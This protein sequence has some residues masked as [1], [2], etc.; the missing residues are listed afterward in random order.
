MG[1]SSFGEGGED[2]ISYESG[3]HCVYKVLQCLSISWSASNLQSC[4]CISVAVLILA[5]LGHLLLE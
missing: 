2:T 3:A 5:F 4:T 1:P